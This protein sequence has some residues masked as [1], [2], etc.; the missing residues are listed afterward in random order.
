MDWRTRLAEFERLNPQDESNLVCGNMRFDLPKPTRPQPINLWPTIIV[1]AAL[2][3]LPLSIFC[4]W[5]GFFWIA[6]LI[7]PFLAATA[8]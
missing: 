1:I 3:A 7:A 6:L 2:P 8:E 4:P 5:F